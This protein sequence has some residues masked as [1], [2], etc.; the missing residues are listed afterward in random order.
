MA[1]EEGMTWADLHCLGRRAG[2]LMSEE[3]LGGN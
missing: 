2:R 1:L 3:E